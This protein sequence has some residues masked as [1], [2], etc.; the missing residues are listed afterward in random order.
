LLLP[1]LLLGELA[2]LSN[3]LG[4]LYTDRS[5]NIALDSH[6]GDSAEVQKVVA[7]RR[8]APRKDLGWQKLFGLVFKFEIGR[9]LSFMTGIICRQT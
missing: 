7:P 8:L 1:G 2:C 6:T 9:I 4:L 3:I 5:G